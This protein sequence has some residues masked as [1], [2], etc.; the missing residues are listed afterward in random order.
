MRFDTFP[1]VDLLKPYIRHF[2]LS[3]QELG[4]VYKVFPQT[5]LVIGFQYAGQLSERKG[6]QEIML[7]T[8]GNEILIERIPE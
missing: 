4:N 6:D 5:G 7:A 8:A 3:E 2:V 1:P